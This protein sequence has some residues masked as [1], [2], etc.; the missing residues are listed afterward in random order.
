MDPSWTCSHFSLSNPKGKR[1]GDL[2]M[3]SRR[4]ATR[5]AGLGEN[6]MILDVTIAD[7]VTDLGILVQR[8]CLLLGGWVGRYVTDP[9]CPVGRGRHP[10]DLGSGGGS[11]PPP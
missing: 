8:D 9:G 3:L 1:Q 4:P 10:A 2:P 5:I 11:L 6:A 7:E